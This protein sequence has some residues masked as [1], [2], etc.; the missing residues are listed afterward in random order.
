MTAA[1][2][3][4]RRNTMRGWLRVL[5]CASLA[6]AAGCTE[7]P[8]I[9]KPAP[10]PAPAPKPEA[11]KPP[12]PQQVNEAFTRLNSAFQKEYE[13][14][15]AQRGTRTVAVRPQ[16]AYGALHAGLV[17]LGMI[18]ESQDPLAGT[19]T[20]A[21]PAPRPLSIEEWRAVVAADAPMMGAILC[22]VLGAYCKTIR[23]E[24]DDY[25][26]VINATVLPAA[27]SASEVSLTTR[28][29][30]IAPRP[31][32]PR[33]DYPPPTGVHMALDKI[34]ASFEL[35]LGARRRR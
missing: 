9:M 2:I 30:E 21:A 24:P 4:E 35:E 26:I 11:V 29:R 18:V 25:V 1:G 3:F 19:L 7:L 33:R 28:M 23:F 16:D 10:E 34:W 6:L 15:L 5:A 22:P 20:V 17:R 14:I 27:G 12:S 31:G 32:V 8:T 13:R